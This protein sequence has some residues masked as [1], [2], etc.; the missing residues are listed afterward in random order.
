MEKILIG[1]I[2]SAVGLKGEMKVYSYASSPQRFQSLERVWI[3]KSEYPLER[4]RTQKN[5]AVLKVSG[6]DDRDAAERMRGRSVFM[7]DEDLEELE[8]GA[9]YIRDLIG[10]NVVNEDTEEV[11]GKVKDILTDR[12][13]DIYVVALE[14]GGEAMIPGVKSF[15][16]DVDLKQK[17]IRVHLIEGML[18]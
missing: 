5:M 15:I 18:G 6:I 9:Y 7:S 4:S 10:L 1:K 3:D 17:T 2:T 13:Q 16:H 14:D 8:E 11:I 12:P